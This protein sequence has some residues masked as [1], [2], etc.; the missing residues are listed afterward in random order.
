MISR[1]LTVKLGSEYLR[2]LSVDG[3]KMLYHFDACLLPFS[4]L[5]APSCLLFVIEIIIPRAYYLTD[6]A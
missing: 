6:I 3:L 1:L 5:L 4:L 2:P